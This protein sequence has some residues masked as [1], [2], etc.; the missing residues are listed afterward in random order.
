MG[1][2][3]KKIIAERDESIAPGQ[4]HPDLF[5]RDAVEM[6][7]AL[8]YETISQSVASIERAAYIDEL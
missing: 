8:L 5:C 3:E 4:H 6:Y 1:R 7:G 2:I